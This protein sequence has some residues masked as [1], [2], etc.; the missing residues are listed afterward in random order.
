MANLKDIATLLNVEI[1]SKEKNIMEPKSLG[2]KRRSWL[3]E[4]NENTDNSKGVYR[5]LNQKGSINPVDQPGLSTGL[6]N[7]VYQ[8]IEQ[9]GSINQVDQPIYISLSLLRS[10]PLSIIKLLY[11]YV[12]DKKNYITKNTTLSEIMKTLEISRDSARTGLRFLLKN[13]LIERVDFK[14][15]KSGWSRYQIRKEL[16]EEIEKHP[17]KGFIDPLRKNIQ[18]GSNSSSSYY[19]NT[20]TTE[21]EKD[22]NFSSSES[23]YIDIE[24]LQ[25]H[26]FSK[27]HFL[28]IQKLGKLETA[29]IQ[30]S[31]YAFAFDLN[32]N[33][34]TRVIK[35]SVI[36]YFMGILR[37][38]VVYAFP[39]NYESPQD[40]ALRLYNE[41]KQA[42]IAK[43]V[44][45]EQQAFE[46]GF[47]EWVLSLSSTQREDL[48]PKDLIPTMYKHKGMEHP[49][50]RGALKTHFKEKV[51]TGTPVLSSDKK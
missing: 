51:W 4:D 35:G 12:Q 45:L 42:Q 29:A 40:E 5:P 48:V 20:T 34:K 19:I 43:R 8:P 47:D 22:L 13:K 50:I 44:E 30:D 28:Q 36:N 46:L 33:D 10:N 39:E 49:G 3:I 9:K 17:Q 7:R 38:G 18:K 11:S 41:R 21:E 24:P 31:I 32:N 23:D 16:Y 14:E 27:H 37:K 26:G 15:G 1:K 25:N 6:I 2:Q